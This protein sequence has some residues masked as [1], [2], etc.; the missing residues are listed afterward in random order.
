MSKPS[1]IAEGLVRKHTLMTGVELAKRIY[2]PNASDKQVTIFA[3][4]FMKQS[5]GNYTTSQRPMMFQGTFGSAMGLFQTYML[6]YAQ[7]MYRHLDLKDYKGLG[8]TMLAQGG[9]FGAGSVPG[10][11]PISE[12]IGENFSDENMDL[13]RGLYRGLPDPIANVIVYGLPSNLI[14]A[15]HTRGDVT[16]RIPTGVTTLVAPSMIGQILGSMVDVGKSIGQA[17]VNSGQAFMEALSAQ[18]VSRPIARLS[19]LASGYAVTRQGNQIAG[20][21]EVWSW[22]GILARTFATRTLKEAKVREAIHINS[23]YAA[24]NKA[25]RDAVLGKLRTA[26]RGDGVTD[27]L[28][29][30]LAN[31]YLR[32][33]SPQGFR[34]AVN[35]AFMENSNEKLV[36]LHGKLGNSPLMLMLDDLD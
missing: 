1:E 25:N 22:Q 20:Q 13:Q 2:G 23:V 29:D 7:N 18:S 15:L 21:E 19:E 5:L 31:E 27:D 36:D 32:T 3:R 4:D 33:G 16:P 24:S 26:I 17:D 11:A 30:N 12:V 14:G 9:I 10:F 8:K 34:Q 6:T 35:Q 28:M